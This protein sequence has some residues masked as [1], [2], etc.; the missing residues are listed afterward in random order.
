[1]RWGLWEELGPK[2]RA[3]MNEVSALI[4]EAERAPHLFN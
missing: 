1:M 2:G 3:L 4:K